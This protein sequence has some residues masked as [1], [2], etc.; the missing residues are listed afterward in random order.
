MSGGSYDYLYSKVEDVANRLSDIS[1]TPLRR[2]FAEHL[3]LVASA[4][5]DIEWVDSGDMGKDGDVDAIRAVL[6]NS[7]N[8]QELSVLLA[9]FERLADKVKEVIKNV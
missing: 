7:A 8:A 1:E 3:Q 2:A 6:G 4:L 9:D 5:H